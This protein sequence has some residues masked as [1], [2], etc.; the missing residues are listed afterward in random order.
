MRLFR[1]AQAR[2]ATS[3]EHM[4]DGMGAYRVGGRWNSKGVKAVYLAETLSLATL[5]I[6]V[7]IRIPSV[8]ERYC[9]VEV[10]VDAELL[11][12]LGNGTLEAEQVAIGNAILTDPSRLGLLA[13]SVVN[14]FERN[15]VLNRDYP[16]FESSVTVLTDVYDYPIDPRLIGG[17][18]R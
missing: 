3:P 10:E 13:A 7:H 12:D 4:L 16:G 9:C 15:V 8:L 2:H 14:P 11:V 6:L 18:G 17:E 5:E 1:L